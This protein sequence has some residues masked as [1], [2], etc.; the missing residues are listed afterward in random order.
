[1][2]KFKIK[3]L[4]D[5]LPRGN[6]FPACRQTLTFFLLCPHM[7]KREVG[8]GALFSLPL[9]IRTLISS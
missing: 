7:T 1:M 4:A 2:G 3:V 6:L 5:S 8:E 9:L